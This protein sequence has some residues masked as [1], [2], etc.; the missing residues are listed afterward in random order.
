[1][2]GAARP[3]A[4]TLVLDLS[5]VLAGPFCTMLL[6]DLGARVVKV[7]NPDGGDVTRG[8][9]PP[10]DG[11][12]GLSAYYLAVNRNK[13]SIALDL[14][15]PSGAESVRILARRADVV[16]ENFLPGGLEKLGLSLAGLRSENPRLVTASITAA[17]RVGEESS[18]PGFDLLAQAGTGLMAITG[19]AGGGPAKVGVAVS[20]LFAGCFALAGILGLLTAREKSGR[21]GHVEIDL[22]TSSLAA[23]INVA[24]AALLTETEAK[25]WGNSHPQI[26]PY[27]PFD[28]SD[29]SFIVAAGTDRHFERLCRVVGREE[30]AADAAYRTNSARLQNR[31]AL[32]G[33]LETI[34]RVRPR[35][36]WIAAL[37]AAGVPAGPVRGPLE[38]LRSAVSQSLN[39]V[40]AAGGIDFVASPIR[41]EGAP[42]PLRFPA[43]L[44]EQGAAL[45]REFGLPG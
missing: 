30:W 4:G 10:N 40:A 28:A 37:R 29:G 16:V 39:A 31:A 32:E 24:Q 33:D 14:S 1:M 36:E 12:S 3:L 27:R 7:E 13:E 17:G 15:T 8:W 34:F 26:V 25:R 23:L 11:E 2:T 5:R 42:A 19:S 44:D 18:L 9:G 6:A 38:A 35:A 21:G 41:L 22:F 20:D 45:R 43:K